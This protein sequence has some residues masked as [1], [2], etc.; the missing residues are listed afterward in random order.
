[1]QLYFAELQE[2]LKRQEV[3][4]TTVV[5]THVREKLCMLKQQQEDMAVLLSQ[6]TA[7]CHQCEN[8]LQQVCYI[9]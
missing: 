9:S 4:A 1:M 7:V 8:S 3:A 2:N 6:I 5:D